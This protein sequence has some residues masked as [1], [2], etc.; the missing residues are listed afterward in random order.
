MQAADFT[1]DDC[2]LGARRFTYRKLQRSHVC[3]PCGGEL[4][5]RFG[6]GWYICCAACGSTDLVSRSQR[7]RQQIEARE[8]LWEMPQTI[9]GQLK[10]E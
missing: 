8:V 2:Q 3:Q 1:R 6:D 9:I 5:I 4:T 10:G 7:E